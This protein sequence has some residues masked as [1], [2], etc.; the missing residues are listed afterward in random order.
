MEMADF[1]AVLNVHIYGTVKPARALWQTFRDQKYGRIVVTTSSSGLYGNFG[2]ANYTTAKMGLVGLMNTLRLEG[3]RDNIKVNAILPVA[4]TRMTENLL[5]PDMQA[6]LRPEFVTPGV[7]YLASEDAPT[8][9][10][11]S[12]A[13]GVYAA[14]RIEQCDGVRL[15]TKATADDVAANFARI[16]DFSNAKHYEEGTEM[17]QNFFSHLQDKPLVG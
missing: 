14:A 15:G 2:Q 4:A 13:A 11:L 8:G 10:I 3:A 16:A 12:A 9:I 7:V 1:E 5:P 6:L 17:V